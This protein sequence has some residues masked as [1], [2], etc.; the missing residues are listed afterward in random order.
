MHNSDIQIFEA[1]A[2]LRNQTKLTKLLKTPIKFTTANAL[3]FATKKLNRP[4]EL[5]T[6]TFWGDKMHVVFPE[7]MSSTI[8]QYGCIDKGQTLTR[9]LLHFLKP[10]MT[11]FDVGSHYG[12]FSLLASH[13]V[14]DENAGGGDKYTPLNP[15]RALSAYCKR[16][17][18]QSR[19][20]TPTTTPSGTK[21]QS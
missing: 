7:G 19:T 16:M 9:A 11:F 10:G 21:K 3:R 8:Y 6:T 18:P 15:R 2:A 13:M 20:S 4:L 12:Y 5:Q 17:P 14:G 1:Q